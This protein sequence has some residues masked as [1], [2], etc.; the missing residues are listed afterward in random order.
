MQSDTFVFFCFLIENLPPDHAAPARGRR[1]RR[2]QVRR[3]TQQQQQ[4]QRFHRNRNP[5]PPMQVD[6]NAAAVSRGRSTPPNRRSSDRPTRPRASST[7]T[8]P[9]RRQR[10]D[11]H[12]SY[13]EDSFEV[14]ESFDTADEYVDADFTNEVHT[15][16][17]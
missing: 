6:T 17:D 13:V 5:N 2:S 1:D 16:N 11:A 7:P 14:G 15:I 10:L 9:R 8:S 12:Q 3:S 4:Q